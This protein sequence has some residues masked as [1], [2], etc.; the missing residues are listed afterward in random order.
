MKYEKKQILITVK[1]YPNPSRKYQETVCCAGIDI[2]N[3]KLIRLYPIPF[4][5]LDR[6]QKFKKYSIINVECT[7]PSDDNRPESYKVNSDS[8]KILYHLSSKQEWKDRKAIIYKSPAKSMCQVYKDAEEKNLSLG[9]VRPVNIT[10]ECE[11]RS[12]TDVKTREECYSQLSFFNKHK[13]AIEAI[14]FNFYYKFHC[15]DDDNCP[16]HKL[17][18]ID[19]EIGQAY[20]DWRLRYGSDQV[21]AKI[22]EKWLDIANTEKRD[23]LFYVGNMKRFRNNFMVL[24]VFYPPKTDSNK[25]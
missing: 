17:S 7:T 4:R 8:I 23:V 24:G 16:G 2:I 6:S 1:A 5:D 18:I 12:R 10:F 11:K 3:Y 14:P 25:V 13:E 15:A 19:W 22:E 9:I 20:R 21:L